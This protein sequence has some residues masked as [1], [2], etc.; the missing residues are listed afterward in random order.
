MALLAPTVANGMTAAY[1]PTGKNAS[2]VIP[3][4]AQH[5]ITVAGGLHKDIKGTHPQH[6]QSNPGPYKPLPYQISIS[7]LGA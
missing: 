2:Q 7:G 4:M 1:Y 6:R 5:S 3:V